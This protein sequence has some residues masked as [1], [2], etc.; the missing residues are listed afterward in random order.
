M[1]RRYLKLTALGVA[2]SLGLCACGGTD[3]GDA[4][5]NEA[6]DGIVRPTDEQ[7]GTLTFAHSNEFDSMDPGNTYYA[8]NWNFSRFYARRLVTYAQQPGEAGQELV[9]DLATD[10]GE[11]SDDGLTWTYTLKEGVKYQDGSP[12][13]AEHIKYAIARSNFATDVINKGPTYFADLLDEDDYAGPYQ[14]SDL[15]N[16]EAIETPDER[17]IVFHLKEPFGEFDYLATMPQTAPVPPDADT[18]TQY[19]TEVVSS[20]PYQFD[21]QWQPGSTLTLVRNEHYDP[22]TDPLVRN[23]PDEIQ[24]SFK[25]N[26]DDIDNR[27]LSGDLLVGAAGVG[28]QTAARGRI[29]RDDNLKA[30]S[31][32][33]KTAFLFYFAINPNVAPF[34]NKACR[35]AV[36]YGADKTQLQT[37]F[38]GPTAGDIATSLLPPVVP[39]YEEI[40]PYGT[41]N[42][43]GD[44][45]KTRAKLAECGHEDGFAANI[46]YRSDRPAGQKA[47][48]ALQASLSE[49]GI[50]TDLKGYPSGTYTNEQ[51]GS[52]EFV[53]QEELGI[54][55][56]GWGP[57]WNSGYGFLSQIVD[58]DAIKPA[59]NSNISE[60]DNPEINKLLDEAA[61]SQDKQ[62]REE[63]YARID[64]LAMDSATFLPFAN[65]KVLLYRPEE[66]TNVFVNPNYHMYDYVSLGVA[67]N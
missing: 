27:L 8:A 21:G 33:P 20:G 23:L 38:G 47:A 29:L 59:G 60:L 65:R 52:P 17:T 14:D 61:Q 41:P 43:E 7:G 42:H 62:R 56:Y 54:M 30:R 40:D 11:V 37:A 63:I 10:L 44:P 45:D 67:Q 53:R 57:D 12:I 1:K 13:V 46:A 6:V 49:Y 55:I 35:E 34:D 15:D 48:E 19:Q 25:Q 28:V 2:A 36:L 5:Q 31:D 16:F 32:N 39:G 24:L 4:A 26:A 22:E 3:S 66:L 64:E 18:G 58:G 51:A 9:P 50:T